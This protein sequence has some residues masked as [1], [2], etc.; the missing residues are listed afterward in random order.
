MIRTEIRGL[1]GI[2][3]L[4]AGLPQ[5]VQ[6]R[7]LRQALRRGARLIADAAKAESPVDTGN[8]RRSITVHYDRRLPVT[9]VGWNIWA[10]GSVALRKRD[11]GQIP[12]LS[13]KGLLGEN[14]KGKP[15]ASTF[16][17]RF[18]EFGTVH[19]AAQPFMTPALTGRMKD[20]IDATAL[21]VRDLLPG[22]VGRM[23]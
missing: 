1:G 18:Q 14:K 23:R 13:R 17:A 6:K 9:Q 21:G 7:V 16:Y 4:L 22:I 11:A 19:H 20:A 5:N 2:T 12:R 8:L 10:G 15:V 3:Q